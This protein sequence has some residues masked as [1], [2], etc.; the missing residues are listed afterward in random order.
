ME[1]E[2]REVKD[3]NRGKRRLQWWE[4]RLKGDI[5][6]LSKEWRLRNMNIL[7]AIKVFM[8]R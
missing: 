2:G 7:T 6:V 8:H 4:V 1:K 3:W 5:R